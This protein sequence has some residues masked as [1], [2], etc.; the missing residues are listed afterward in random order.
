MPTCFVIG[1]NHRLA[2]FARFF[3]GLGKRVGDSQPDQVSEESPKDKPDQRKND[4][5][6]EEYSRADE[7]AKKGV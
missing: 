3:R 2:F 6:H 7:Q 1:V 4:P 5:T